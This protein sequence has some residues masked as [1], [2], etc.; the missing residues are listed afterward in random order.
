[1]PALDFKTLEGDPDFQALTNE[2]KVLLLQRLKG[3]LSTSGTAVQ[4]M[5]AEE[6]ARLQA[7]TPTLSTPVAPVRDLSQVQRLGQSAIADLRR[8]PEVEPTNFFGDL[9]RGFTYGA[10]AGHVDEPR[11][12]GVGTMLG[13]SL[14]PLVPVGLGGLAGSL[15]GPVGSVVGGG[16]AGAATFGEL[17]RIR[18]EK[19]GEQPD[20]GKI[21]TAAV[22]GGVG[23]AIPILRGG[24]LLTQILKNA[25][26]GAGLGAGETGVR[27]SI[28]QRFDLGELGQS[29]AGGAVFSGALGALFPKVKAKHPEI[30]AKIKAG[31]PLTEPEAIKVQNLMT[32][33]EHTALTEAWRTRTVD[34][35]PIIDPRKA[36]I[37]A[38]LGL[39]K[40][41]PSQGGLQIVTR[42]GTREKPPAPEILIDRGIPEGRPQ[43]IG[44]EIN[45]L[46]GEPYPTTAPSAKASAEAIR[47]NLS[48][49]KT[50][51][52]LKNQAV[53]A[54]QQKVK[55]LRRFIGSDDPVEVQRLLGA[56]INE[57]EARSS[58][59]SVERQELEVLR[60]QLDD[61]LTYGREVN[62]AEAL[63]SE[64]QAT[65]PRENLPAD[66][67][68]PQ[69]ALPVE[70]KAVLDLADAKTSVKEKPLPQR[71]PP[72][73]AQPLLDKRGLPI[74]EKP[75][76][77]DLALP[78]Q[79][80]KPSG[81]EL[82]T[83][84]G[85]PLDLAR[86]EKKPLDLAIPQE[87]AVPATREGAFTDT[88][89]ELLKGS[90]LDA[91]GLRKLKQDIDVRRNLLETTL[92]HS[93]TDEAK[94]L[95]SELK[96]L[97]DRWKALDPNL[98]EVA[99]TD[100]DPQTGTA[101]QEPIDT[102][103]QFTLEQV[104][105][106]LDAHSAP[107]AAQ[108]WEGLQ[109]GVKV[110]IK[111][112][113][114]QTGRSYEVAKLSKGG[115]AV[116]E[117]TEFSPTHF[118]YYNATFP[119]GKRQVPVAFGYNQRGHEV[120]YYLGKSPK[121]SHIQQVVSVTDKPAFRGPIANVAQGAGEYNVSDILAR[122]PRTE[123]GFVKTSEAIR[124]IHE[125]KA[126][127]REAANSNVLAPDVKAQVQKVFSGKD[128]SHDDIRSM[129][130]ALSSPEKIA[131]L[132]K[133][134]GLS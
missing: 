26:V 28:D 40:T 4:R 71:Q 29:A 59:S 115:R 8:P 32:P 120:G 83:A 2:N 63:L 66:Y 121:G 62:A 6:D 97:S 20:I 61:L 124:A 47:G 99:G 67:T 65:T 111:F 91:A 72:D 133:R 113:G 49:I 70:R 36:P 64:V 131:E 108:I 60:T 68:P 15:A 27:Q 24:R 92:K 104:Q 127:I 23:S 14:G 11:G 117:T 82:V 13:E 79:E 95:R 88:V 134:M 9:A 129:K 58:L 126:A 98:Q 125:Q 100:F 34:P 1:M 53:R 73:L 89:T 116:V 128:L 7:A 50:A 43:P 96:D 38:D 86:A 110:R 123:R 21:G 57:L 103:E 25:A 118:G 46:T 18:E 76:P 130:K 3:S 74:G 102:Q 87:T 22:F 42:A 51:E 85:R 93:R 5:Q 30:A 54:Y 106:D 90:G 94:R 80:G 39:V 12:Q 44:N 16:A 45:P 10:S 41:E 31:Q 69:K 33:D 48:D 81:G 37:P 84:S 109:K 77:V 101:R 75:P 56:K 105:K 122:G 35:K 55:E 114:E 78:R 19:A 107:I 119:G 132:C 52:T 112:V 17:E